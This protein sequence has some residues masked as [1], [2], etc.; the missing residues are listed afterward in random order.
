MELREAT[1]EDLD[2]LTERWYALAQEMEEYDELNELAFDSVEEVS[3]DGF[4]AHLDDEAVA[5]YLIDHAG[6]AIGFLTLRVETHPSRAYNTALRIVN[7]AIDE[8]HRNEGHGAAVL[9]R[10]ESIASERG[11]D[12]LT[13]G[14]EW[15]ND[16]ARRFYRE[17]GF[18][19]KQA[20]YAHSLE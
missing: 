7:V 13:V 18:R 5:D 2:A 8:G 3:N 9:D 19:P 1:A 20:E 11:C 10:V 12:H 14:C 17:W 15:N 16:G 6:E 4:R